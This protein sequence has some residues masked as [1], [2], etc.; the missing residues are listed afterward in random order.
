MMNRRNFLETAA[1]AAAG[2]ATAR[3]AEEELRVGILGTDNSHS[4]AFAKI[5]NADKAFPGV[6]V[7]AMYGRDP[8]R[9]K[10]M[11]AKGDISNIVENP[12]DMLDQ[13][14]VAIV[15]FRHGGLHAEYALPFLERGIATF[16]DKPF[17]L[18]TDDAQQMI[19]A[20][21]QNGAFLTSF[22]TVRWGDEVKSFMEEL[23]QAGE[24]IAG[25][26]AGPGSASSEYGGFGFYGIHAI[27]LLTHTIA[28]KIVFASAV[29][30]GDRVAGL[31]T[32]ES[33]RV[34]SIQVAG[35]IGGFR[36]HA[37]TK[38][39]TLT[40]KTGGDYANGL[41]ALFDGIRSGRPPLNYETLYEQ[42]AIIEAMEASMAR[43][44]ES[45]EVK[46]MC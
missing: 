25:G 23:N 28:D 6:K 20:A 16:V 22:S 13:V 12:A 15:D 17:A 4:G 32:A 26:S 30:E 2:A 7:V 3:A 29:R 40:L 39:E 14:N 33:G 8:D 37:V 36:L 44:G 46:C 11:A 9:T 27:E 31:L 21:E 18:K 1:L 10:E 19:R 38:D 43:K 5:I 41:R 24:A 34:F 42:V 35:G 45:V